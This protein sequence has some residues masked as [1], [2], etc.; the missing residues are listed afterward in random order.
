MR[1]FSTT[2]PC[3][4]QTPLFDTC[5]R[6]ASNDLTRLANQVATLGS[7]LVA[8]ANLTSC[9][10]VVDGPDTALAVQLYNC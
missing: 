5:G 10:A 1:D 2:R 4:P 3:N 7:T 9:A 8:P 6:K